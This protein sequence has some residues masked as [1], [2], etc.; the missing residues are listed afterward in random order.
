MKNEKNLCLTVM[1]TLYFIQLYE[2][3]LLTVMSPICPKPFPTLIS[4]A[5]I[6]LTPSELG[7][8]P[9][10]NSTYHHHH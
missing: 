10:K 8:T 6:S 1:Y 5:Y 4:L 9:F 3:I 7:Q 2:Y